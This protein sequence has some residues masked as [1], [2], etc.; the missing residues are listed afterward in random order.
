MVIRVDRDEYATTPHPFGI[1][2]CLL[3]WDTEVSEGTDDA[4]GSCSNACPR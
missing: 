2:V 4:A 1:I 3:F